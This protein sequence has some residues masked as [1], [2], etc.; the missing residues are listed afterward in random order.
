MLTKTIPVLPGLAAWLVAIW[1]SRWLDGGWTACTLRTPPAPPGWCPVVTLI[2]LRGVCEQVHF[3]CN[4]L[5]E[6]LGYWPRSPSLLTTQID[7]VAPSPEDRTEQKRN[8]PRVGGSG[9]GS[10]SVSATLA[11]VFGDGPRQKGTQNTDSLTNCLC[12]WKCKWLSKTKRI[13]KGNSFEIRS[14][15]A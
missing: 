1:V 6:A 10:A 5:R 11:A 13:A 12:K 7:R 8:W 3:I 15:M 2:N 9:S 4:F 14:E